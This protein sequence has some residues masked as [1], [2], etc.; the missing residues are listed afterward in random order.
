MSH[1]HNSE[2]VGRSQSEAKSEMEA[3]H[4]AGNMKIAIF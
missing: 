4:G 2:S 3:R 1:S